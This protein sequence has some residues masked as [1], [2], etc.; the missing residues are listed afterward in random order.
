MFDNI[1]S[2]LDLVT[3]S[4]VIKNIFSYLKENN[5]TG[6]IASQKISTIANCDKIVVLDNGKIVDIGTHTE[7]LSRCNLYNEIYSLQG[8]INE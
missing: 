7:L 8:E 2:S 3:E 6:L 4:K 1:T 5:I